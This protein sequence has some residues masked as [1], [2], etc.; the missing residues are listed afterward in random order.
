MAKI[1]VIKTGGKQYKVSQGQN[2]KIEKINAPTGEILKFQTLMTAEDDKVELGRPVL[3]QGVE[4]KIIEQGRSDK[5]SVIKFKNKTR[6]KRN[7]GHRQPFTKVE[8]VKISG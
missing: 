6:Y 8:I 1:A 5:V 7:L 2:L 3:G 4:G